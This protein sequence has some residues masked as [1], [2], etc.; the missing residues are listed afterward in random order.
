MSTG[1]IAAVT[2]ALIAVFGL[3]TWSFVSARNTLE[4]QVADL[5]QQIQTVR[6]SSAAH[7]SEVASGIQT[8]LQVVS[9]KIGVTAKELADARKAANLLKQ[10]HAKAT[11]RLATELATRDQALGALREQSSTASTKITELAQGQN[12]A[13]SKI[14]AVTGDVQV[15]KS[16]LDSTKKD[17]AA[18]RSEMGNIK[19]A[20]GREIAKN[21][22]EVAELRRRGER[23]YQEF[24]I[25]KA[26]NLERVAT[27]VQIQLKKADPKAQRYD[28]TMMVDDSKMEKKNLLAKE[29]IQFL[30]GRDRLR[31]ELVVFSVDKD[32][33]RGYISMPKD[34]V[35]S[36]E[37]PRPAR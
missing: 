17:L 1:K 8:D 23:D 27:G 29:P 2:A 20:L 4:G 33:I 3:Q 10:E 16:D 6:D 7:V 26:N 37:G 13:V 30:V 18:S 19:D 28:V 36:A 32:R 15:V 35:L 12:E 24:N 31:Y 9:D 25:A 5:Q 11:E 21:S 22:S 14:G 34:G